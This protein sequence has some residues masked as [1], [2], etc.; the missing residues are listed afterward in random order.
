[1]TYVNVVFSVIKTASYSDVVVHS[2][3]YRYVSSFCLLRRKKCM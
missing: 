3:I 1:M 2:I